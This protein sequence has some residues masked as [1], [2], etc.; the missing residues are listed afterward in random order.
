[1]TKFYNREAITIETRD[2]YHAASLEAQGFKEVA[3]PA[4]SEGAPAPK[5]DGAK[6]VSKMTV[7][8][9]KAHAEANSIALGEATTKADILKA[10]TDAATAPAKAEEG[11]GS[12]PAGDDSDL[13]GDGAGGEDEA[14]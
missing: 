13:L 8:E 14:L 3:A 7:P 2:P 4:K 5:A 6:L 11:D 10:I 1:M 12:A 9:L